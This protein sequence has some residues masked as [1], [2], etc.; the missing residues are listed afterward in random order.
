[1]EQLGQILEKYY[2]SKKYI[3]LQK[4]MAQTIRD[5]LTRH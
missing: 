1:M 3:W 5:A 4:K 2:S